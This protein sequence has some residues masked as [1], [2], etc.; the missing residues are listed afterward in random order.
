MN[1]IQPLS[2]NEELLKSAIDGLVEF[3]PHLT[4][5]DVL[6]EIKGTVKVRDTGNDQSD[7]ENA[8][9]QVEKIA[10]AWESLV[11][12]EEEEKEE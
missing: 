12:E 2:R 10:N 7:Y 5:A 9:D 8:R 4:R 6:A 11:A 1:M 3:Y